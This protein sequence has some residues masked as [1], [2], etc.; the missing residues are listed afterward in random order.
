MPRK[1]SADGMQL[2]PASSRPPSATWAPC[3]SAAA[4]ARTPAA[5]TRTSAAAAASASLPP[6]QARRETG[7]ANSVSSRDSDSSWRAAEIW[8]QAKRPIAKVKIRK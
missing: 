6:S 2:R 8:A 3:D 4:Q 7:S 5:S 1:N